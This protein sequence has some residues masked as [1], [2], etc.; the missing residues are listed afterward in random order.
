MKKMCLRVRLGEWDVNSDSEFYENRE[1]EVESITIHPQ[2]HPGL[3]R[4]IDNCQWQCTIEY[5]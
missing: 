4:K 1:Y 2:Y 3:L 5:I